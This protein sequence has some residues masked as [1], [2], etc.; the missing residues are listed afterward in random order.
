MLHALMRRTRSAITVAVLA[1]AA[2]APAV[3]TAAPAQAASVSCAHHTTGVCGTGIK[4]PPGVMA[5]C[6][7]GSWSRSKHFSGTCSRHKGVRYWFK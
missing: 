4:H 7:D 2:I 5:Q 6:N 3:I 1:T